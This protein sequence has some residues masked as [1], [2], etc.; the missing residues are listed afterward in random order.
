MERNTNLIKFVEG[1]IDISFNEN[2]GKD[3]VRN[4]T[5][6]LLK[7]TGKRWLITL[8]KEKGGKTFSELRSIKEQETL[9]EEKK[10]EVYKKFKSVFSDGDLIEVTKEE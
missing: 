6:K 1:K 7:W 2:L 3:F 9:E 4:L 8:T 10:S 5:E